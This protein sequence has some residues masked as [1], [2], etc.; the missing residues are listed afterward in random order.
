RSSDLSGGV[1]LDLFGPIRATW[2]LEQAAVET[3]SIWFPTYLAELERQIGL[4]NKTI[5]R[6]PTPES[7]HGGVDL[8]SYF[9]DELPEVV[10]VVNPLGPPERSASAGYVQ[11]YELQVGCLWVGTGSRL[12]ERPEHEAR[13]IASYLGA[14]SMLLVQQ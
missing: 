10:V 11:G 8:E 12:Q 14:A 13:A 3:L 1:V 5:P 4:T 7:Y 2:E 6:P 9:Q